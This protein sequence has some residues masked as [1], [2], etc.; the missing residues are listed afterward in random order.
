[1][2]FYKGIWCRGVNGISLDCYS[3]LRKCSPCSDHGD[4]AGNNSVCRTVNTVRRW[5]N[6]PCKAVT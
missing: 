3:S 6:K 1:M 5:R 2:W 4:T